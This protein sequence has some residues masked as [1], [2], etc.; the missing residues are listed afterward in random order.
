[1]NLREKDISFFLDFDIPDDSD[2]RI[3]ASDDDEDNL[4]FQNK[5]VQNPSS[6]DNVDELLVTFELGNQYHKEIEEDALQ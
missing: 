3:C 1:M 2:T 5:T 4:F 6:D